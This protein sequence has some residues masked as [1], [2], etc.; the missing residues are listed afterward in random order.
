VSVTCGIHQ[1][2]SWNLHRQ[3]KRT[4]VGTWLRFG[5]LPESSAESVVARIMVSATPPSLAGGDL[6]L[7]HCEVMS[8]RPQNS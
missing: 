3:L 4:S 7:P 2:L 5:I 6:S 8:S 1:G